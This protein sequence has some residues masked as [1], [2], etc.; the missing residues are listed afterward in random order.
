[1]TPHSAVHGLAACVA[2]LIVTACGSSDTSTPAEVPA[3]ATPVVVEPTPEPPPEPEPKLTQ[4]QL[5]RVLLTLNDMPEAGFVISAPDDSEQTYYCDYK[6]PAFPT[7][8]ATAEFEKVEGISFYLVRSNVDQYALTED[9]EAML[10]KTTRVLSR[11]TED[12]IDGT[13]FTFTVMSAPNLADQSLGVKLEATI[14]GMDVV[15]HQIYIRIGNAI[16]QTSAATGGMTFPD[17]NEVG[18]L[19]EVQV[20]RY[21]QAAGS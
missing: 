20:D 2:L 16:V 19:A 5:N 9:A 13:R 7:E 3:D 14:D 11:C 4:K 12:T 8:T 21:L 15:M 10:D 1:M 6:P 18:E 17:A